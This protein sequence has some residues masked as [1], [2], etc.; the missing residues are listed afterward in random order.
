MWTCYL[1]WQQSPL[2][3]YSCGPAWVFLEALFFSEIRHGG[4]P[5]SRPRFASKQRM[6]REHSSLLMK[7]FCCWGSPVFK[8]FTELVEASELLL[9]L[10]PGHFSWACSCGSL[11]SSICW[12]LATITYSVHPWQCTVLVCN[13]RYTSW[14]HI[15]SRR[16]LP[17]V[18]LG[19]GKCSVVK[20]LATQAWGFDFNPH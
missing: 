4:T 2:L 6:H 10:P 11:F 19:L 1:L 13:E 12:F 3:E 7:T 5:P 9:S 20:V 18:I 15:H 14:P 17:E 16:K 8:L